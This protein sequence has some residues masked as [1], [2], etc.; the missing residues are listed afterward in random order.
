MTI[1]VLWTA[2]MASANHKLPQQEQLQKPLESLLPHVV[3]VSFVYYKLRGCN[4]HILNWTKYP[5]GSQH[6]A[7]QL[8]VNRTSSAFDACFSYKTRKYI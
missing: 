5:Q 4:P 7:N 2:M 6:Y 8:S 1:T 3:K